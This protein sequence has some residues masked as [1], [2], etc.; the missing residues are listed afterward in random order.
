M[1]DVEQQ[2]ADGAVLR[3]LHSEGLALV[4]Q[5]AVVSD[6]S[7]IEYMIQGEKVNVE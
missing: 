4:Q 3:H 7:E 6:I 2:Q 1:P 5:T